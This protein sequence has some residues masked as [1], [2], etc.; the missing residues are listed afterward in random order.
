MAQRLRPHGVGS[1][2]GLSLRGSSA[3]WGAFLAFFGALSPALAE[4]PPELA[5]SAFVRSVSA[6]SVEG[7]RDDGTR[8]WK[9]SLRRASDVRDVGRA[10]DAALEA[11]RK[12]QASEQPQ[13]VRLLEGL[14]LLHARLAMARA[15][16]VEP[17]NLLRV[18]LQMRQD[19]G[20]W[21]SVVWGERAYPVVS[22]DVAL[23]FKVPEH[24]LPHGDT[25]PVVLGCPDARF[26]RWTETD[27]ARDP[28]PWIEYLAESRRYVEAA[29]R[30]AHL[31]A[32]PQELIVLD[33][34][35]SAFSRPVDLK[36]VKRPFAI[37]RVSVQEWA[38]QAPGPN[39]GPERRRAFLEAWREIQATTYAREYRG[40]CALIAQRLVV[41]ALAQTAPGIRAAQR[42]SLL[43]AWVRPV[44][45]HSV[46]LRQAASAESALVAHLKRGEAVESLVGFDV[47]PGTTRVELADW[48]KVRTDAGETGWVPRELVLQWQG[49]ERSGVL[50]LTLFDVAD[51]ETIADRVSRVDEQATLWRQSSQAIH[52]VRGERAVEAAKQAKDSLDYFCQIK[53]RLENELGRAGVADVARQMRAKRLGAGEDPKAVADLFKETWHN[54]A[55]GLR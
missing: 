35:D 26:E 16:G 17:G 13:A 29:L 38:D 47:A 34:P 53:A 5:Y 6:R 27:I 37:R 41:D 43:G 7:S 23:H 3:L 22:G 4:S 49:P 36:P 11:L 45:Q 8:R 32:V 15:L 12:A 55:C 28:E 33:P 54:P 21:D 40:N 2:R 18:T 42:E 19:G 1:W 30:T 52:R 10:L 14:E 39:D 24:A 50:T 46:P 9:A 48:L 25:D 31:P 44:I 20:G 51:P